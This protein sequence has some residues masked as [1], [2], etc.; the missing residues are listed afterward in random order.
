DKLLDDFQNQEAESRTNVEKDN[1]KNPDTD[2]EY[3]CL[4][5]LSPTVSKP[6]CDPVSS[7][8]PITKEIN[9]LDKAAM[10]I[11]TVP[12]DPES[13]SPSGILDSVDRLVLSSTPVYNK[14]EAHIQLDTH[15]L[16]ETHNEEPLSQPTPVDRSVEE[17]RISSTALETK[18]DVQCNILP[19][20]E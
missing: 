15:S 8:S 6:F 20:G 19:V 16:Y 1:F 7:H 18:S 12:K 2:C 13:K 10:N 11:C 5:G 14:D 17:L 3:A 9:Y 4:I